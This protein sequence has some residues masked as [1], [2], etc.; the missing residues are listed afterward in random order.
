MKPV[1]ILIGGDVCPRG[2]VLPNF[3]SGDAVGIFHDLLDDFRAADLSIVNLECPLTDV[4]SPIPKTGPALRAPSACISALKNAGIHVLNLANNHIL[5]HGAQGVESTLQLAES[6]GIATVGAGRNLAEA[7]RILIRSVG[8]TRIGILAVAEHEFSIA[9]ADSPGANPL[10]L[11]DI[12]RNI[13]EHRGQWDHLIVLLHGGNEGY[14]FPSPRLMDTCRFLVEQGAGA[15]LCQ[16]SHCV[17]C[18]EEYRGG[19]IVYGQGNLVFS[20]PDTLPE[21]DE[22]VLVR[23]CISESGK[24]HLEL[25]PCRQSDLQPGVHKMKQ[26]EAETLVQAMAERSAKIKDPAFVKDQWRQFCNARKCSYLSRVLGHGSFLRH[27]NRHGDV[28]R[29]LY[30]RKSLLGVRNVV[31]CEAHREALDAIFEEMFSRK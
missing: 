6:A 16:H 19:H 25:I 8:D 5:D 30:S 9:A 17:G 18:Y 7:R 28:S 4:D 1:R 13:A 12:V 22:G 29:Y 23:L 2:E 15:V 10:D 26:A 31:L 21:F 14:P 11:I 3:E 27:L 24:S 20:W